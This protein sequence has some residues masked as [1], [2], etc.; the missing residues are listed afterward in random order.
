MTALVVGCSGTGSG[1]A[2]ASTTASPEPAKAASPDT[3]QPE[4]FVVVPPRSGL[5]VRDVEELLAAS[6]AVERYGYLR[7]AEATVRL[8]VPPGRSGDPP[9]C[10]TYFAPG[11]VVEL[12]FGLPEPAVA[13]HDEVAP[14]RLLYIGASAADG[15][16]DEDLGLVARR[17][18]RDFDAEAFLRVGAPPSEAEEVRRLLEADPRVAHFEYLDE[19]EAVAQ[20]RRLFAWNEELLADVSPDLLPKS[21]RVALADGTDLAKWEAE[22]RSQAVVDDVVTPDWIRPLHPALDFDQDAEPFLRAFHESVV[23][24][25]F[26]R[27]LMHVDATAGEIATVEAILRTEPGV[28]ELEVVDRET[29]Y[30]EYLDMVDALDVPEIFGPEDMPISFRFRLTVPLTSTLLTDLEALPGVDTVAA[31]SLLCTPS[32]SA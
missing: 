5:D 13:L 22:Y 27:L 26:A 2:R 18:F 25:G 29:A 21:F 14:A 7:N 31:P 11:F 9:D 10:E 6:D 20:F 1:D 15:F 4:V 19:V 24:P 23:D 17:R 12:D 30:I 16:A 28:E 3:L 8:S 32:A